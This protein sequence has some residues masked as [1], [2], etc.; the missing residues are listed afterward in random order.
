MDGST[1]G[2]CMPTPV[3]PVCDAAMFQEIDDTG[4]ACRCMPGYTRPAGM[5]MCIST[6]VGPACDPAMFQEIDATGAG[7]Q[8]MPGHTRPAGMTTGA[9]TADSNPFCPCLGRTGVVGEWGGAPGFWPIGSLA[10]GLP[11]H[12]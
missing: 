10:P 1:A 4:A 8:C 12:I 9:C 6:P 3:G 2:A 7:C 11:A 5:T